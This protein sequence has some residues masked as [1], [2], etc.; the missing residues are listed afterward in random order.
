MSIEKSLLEILEQKLIE[1]YGFSAKTFAHQFIELNLYCDYDYY[2]NKKVW[3]PQWRLTL[4][5][6]RK[7]FPVHFHGKDPNYV[8]NQALEY[9]KSRDFNANMP[10]V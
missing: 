4:P 6:E 7:D 8:I 10:N 2:N 3:E 9:I 1:R 5:M